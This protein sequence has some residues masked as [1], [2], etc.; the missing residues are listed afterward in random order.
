M[1]ISTTVAATVGDKGKYQKTVAKSGF[2]WKDFGFPEMAGDVSDDDYDDEEEYFTPKPPPPHR[3]EGDDP[4][5]DYIFGDGNMKGAMR[6][7][8]RIGNMNLALS[9]LAR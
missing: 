3:Q 4:S 9:Q 5:M 1:K 2:P 6:D 8:S 7:N